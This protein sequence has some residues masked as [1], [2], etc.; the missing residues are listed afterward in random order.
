MLLNRRNVI[1]AAGAAA[2]AAALGA[3][4]SAQTAPLQVGFIYV[5]PVGDFG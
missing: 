2:G 4:A 1:K 5:G 3:G